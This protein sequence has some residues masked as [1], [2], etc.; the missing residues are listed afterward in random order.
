MLVIIT[1]IL[2]G[3][4]STVSSS[5]LAISNSSADNIVSTNI[6]LL[7]CIAILITDDYISTLKTRNIKKRDW[8]NVTTLPYEKT[9]KTSVVGKK[10]DDRQASDLKKV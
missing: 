4:A 5:T 7:I 9:L 3:C 6:T 1:E 8:I 10:T 2:I